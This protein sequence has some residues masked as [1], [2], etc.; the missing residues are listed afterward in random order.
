MLNV[1][2]RVIILDILIFSWCV[3]LY[4]SVAQ[5]SQQLAVCS[6]CTQPSLQDVG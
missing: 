2:I 1:E 5:V 3:W 4:V 6:W